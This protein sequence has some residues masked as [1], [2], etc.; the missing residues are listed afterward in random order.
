MSVDP[1]NISKPNSVVEFFFVTLVI[2]DGRIEAVTRDHRVYVESNSILESFSSCEY[3]NSRRYCQRLQQ[4]FEYVVSFHRFEGQISAKN[5]EIGIIGADKKVQINAAL[6]TG[7]H[8]VMIGR[9][10]YHKI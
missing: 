8:G 6:K 7:A 10:A 3:R 1:V 5:I 2:L 9:A 4:Y